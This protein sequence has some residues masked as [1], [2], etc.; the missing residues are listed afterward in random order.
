MGIGELP[1]QNDYDMAKDPFAIFSFA[2][3]LITIVLFLFVLVFIAR[4][5]SLEVWDSLRG[6]RKRNRVLDVEQSHGDAVPLMTSTTAAKAIIQHND[7]T[8]PTE[9]GGPLPKQVRFSDIVDSKIL[10]ARPD[11]FEELVEE[12]QAD[13]TGH[14]RSTE[15]KRLSISE[16]QDAELHLSS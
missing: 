15:G 2:L 11:A 9:E 12:W 6:G 14:I 4:W 3:L 16:R 5:S 8:E 13:D 10:P 1:V 7:P